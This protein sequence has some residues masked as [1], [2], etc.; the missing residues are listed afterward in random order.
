MHIYDPQNL[1]DPRVD[2]NI[3]EER[4]GYSWNP[5]GGIGLTI[6]MQPYCANLAG[7]QIYTF[8]GGEYAEDELG[9]PGQTEQGYDV[10]TGD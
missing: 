10:V 1:W 5:V 4:S 6:T 3:A 7:P 8:V 2:A 9:R